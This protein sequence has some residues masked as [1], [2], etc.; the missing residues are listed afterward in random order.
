M[1]ERIRAFFR[2]R[3]ELNRTQFAVRAQLHRN[4]FYGMDDESWNPRI[5][6]VDKLLTAIDAFEAEEGKRRKTRPN[7]FALALA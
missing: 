1:T 7:K 3:P 4:T 2:A 5:E 6:T